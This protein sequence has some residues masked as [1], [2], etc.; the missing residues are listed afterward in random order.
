MSI[1][2]GPSQLMIKQVKEKLS[3]SIHPSKGWV[4]AAVYQHT[5][6]EVF[7]ISQIWSKHCSADVQMWP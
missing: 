6:E 7:L 4:G 1:L 2:L 3:L 5:L